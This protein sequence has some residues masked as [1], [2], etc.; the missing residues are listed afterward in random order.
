MA[1]ES[2][3]HGG[4]LGPALMVIVVLNSSPCLPGVLPFKEAGGGVLRLELALVF[5]EEERVMQQ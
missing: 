2:L 1:N 5:L 3:H 4:R